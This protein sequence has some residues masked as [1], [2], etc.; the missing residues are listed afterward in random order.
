M[1]NNELILQNP[2]PGESFVRFCGDLITFTLQVPENVEGDAWIRTELGR[3]S[4]LRRE[5]INWIDNGDIKLNEQWHD[6]K[7]QKKDQTLFSITLP[8]Y[9]TGHFNAKCFFLARDSTSPVWPVGDNCVI[10]VEPAGTCCANIIYNAFVRQFGRSMYASQSRSSCGIFAA[11]PD[12]H[13]SSTGAGP[14]G[15][16]DESVMSDETHL[17]EQLDK[18]GYSVIPAS[19]K[20]RDLAKEVEFIFSSLGCRALH[21]LP[22]HPV[23][24]T[25]ARMGRFGSPYAALNFAKVDA[26]LAEFDPSATPLEQFMELADTVH[27]YNG[28]LIL[29]I[30]IN[31]TGW[32]AAIHESHPEWLVRGEDGKIEVPGAWG[33]E[34]EDLTKLDYSKKELWQY[35]ADIFLLWC[36]RGVDG[37]RCDAGYMIPVPAWEYMVARVK[38]EYPDTLFFL[39]GLGGPMDTTCDILNRANFNWAYSE[40]F[41]NYDS[42][43]IENYLTQ[44]FELS[45]KYGHL[46]NFAETHDNLRLASVSREYAMMR[47]SIC[48]LFSVCG[49]FGFA[50]GVEWFATKKIDVHESPSL[51]WDS[52]INQVDHIKRL[53]LILKNHP[54]FADQTELKFIQKGDGNYGVLV[55]YHIPTK[56]TILVIANFDSCQCADQNSGQNFGQNSD[57]F[58]ETGREGGQRALWKSCDLAIKAEIFYDLITGKEIKIGRTGEYSFI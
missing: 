13:A 44:S 16:S 50:N 21:L 55:R 56:K 45:K 36:H 23:P 30:A 9:E 57:Q 6:I 3:V 46:I 2:A 41:Q 39:E 54:C 53:N 20:F 18:K 31:H 22:V 11:E 58:S 8:L 47:T 40:L 7:M 26:A 17:I 33:I 12:S 34:W 35:M 37:F 24:T 42:R 15:S 28:Y 19:G 27:L 10:N 4:I 5:I 1:E 52:E 48:A 49:G 43:E 14:S 51:N 38:E 25:Y 29:D 32:A